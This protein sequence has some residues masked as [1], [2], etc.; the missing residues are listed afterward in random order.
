MVLRVLTGCSIGIAVAMMWVLPGACVVAIITGRMEHQSI[1]MTLWAC[2]HLIVFLVCILGGADLGAAVAEIASFNAV[3]CD[4]AF[5]CTATI[6][7]AMIPPVTKVVASPEAHSMN[8]MLINP[9]D[10]RQR[11]EISDNEEEAVIDAST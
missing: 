11:F 4:V 8:E 1:Q 5:I 9:N 7:Y 2:F 3:H 6:S 10:T